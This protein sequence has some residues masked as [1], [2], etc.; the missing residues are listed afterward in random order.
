MPQPG[1]FQFTTI[2]PAPDPGYGNL[3]NNQLPGRGIIN[4]EQAPGNPPGTVTPGIGPQY[5]TPVIH[6]DHLANPYYAYYIQVDYQVSFGNLQLPVAPVSGVTQ[7]AEIVQTRL[8][9]G[10]KVIVWYA[11]RA[12]ASPIVPTPY[13]SD[14]NLVLTETQIRYLSSR[15]SNDGMSRIYRKAGVYIFV[16]LQPQ[17]LGVGNIGYPG[18]DID[19]VGPEIDPVATYAP[20][21]I[22]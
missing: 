16:E 1:Q 10:R 3:Q 18:T 22:I 19:I 9:F 20:N 17:T 21:G 13:I 11:E 2:P 5:T 15:L 12:G 6:P 7:N 8:P 14:P 4:P